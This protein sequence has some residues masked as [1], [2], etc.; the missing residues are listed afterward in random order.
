MIATVFH[1]Q[2]IIVKESWALH[3][4]Q[5]F[6]STNHASIRRLVG[7]SRAVHSIGFLTS[8]YEMLS[9]GDDSSVRLWD[10]PEGKTVSAYKGH[11]DYVRSV[12]ISPSDHN[13]WASGG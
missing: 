12:S 11:T 1:C 3:V 5:I 9:G 7:H 4:S 8:K 10:I 13:V 2:R 6:D